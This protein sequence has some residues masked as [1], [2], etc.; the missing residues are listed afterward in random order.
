MGMS[1]NERARLKLNVMFANT[2]P[3]DHPAWGRR[4]TELL[5]DSV[6]H[7]TPS[8]PVY[9]TVRQYEETGDYSRKAIYDYIYA[10]QQCYNTGAQWI[11]MFEDDVIFADGWYLQ[12]LN[13]LLDISRRI[14]SHTVSPN[15]MYLRLFNQ[16]QLIGFQSKRIGG[17]HEFLISVGVAV[18][19]FPLLLLARKRIR[20]LRHH[21]DNFTIMVIFL[22]AIPSFIV[23]FY[24]SGKASVMP[25]KPGTYLERFGCCSQGLVFPREVVHDVIGYLQFWEKGQIDLMIDHLANVMDYDRYTLYPI[26]LQHVGKQAPIYHL[27]GGLNNGARRAIR[28]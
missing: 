6:Y 2:K 25:P 17:N 26:Q 28:S 9:D 3:R 19:I 22:L 21:V 15:W 18:L 11:A 14:S 16:E 23:L 24:Q 20:T 1:Q 13:S 12:T 7:Y 5:V 4:W 10:L 8:D 27:K